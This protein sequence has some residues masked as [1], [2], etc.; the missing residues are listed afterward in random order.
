MRAFASLY[1]ALDE[2][3]RTTVKVEAMA[4]YFR[5]ADPADAA[6]AVFFL[7]GRR[8]R[9]LLSSGLLRTWSGEEADLPAWLVEECYHAV[10]D[11][12][13]TAALLLREPE[14]ISASKPLHLWVEEVILPLGDQDEDRQRE[15]VAAVWT[16]LPSFE[17]F[18]FN[19]LLTGNFRV[20]VSQKLLV[21]GLEAASAV[22]RQT[23]A[24][25]LMGTW[26]PTPRFFERLVD[27]HTEDADRSR[28]YPFCLAHPV[29][30]DPSS[31]G[32]VKEW[33]AEWKWDGIRA[34]LIRRDGETY[35][36]TR[37]EELVT[38]RY[39]EVGAA[40]TRIPD[41]TVL[42]GELLAWRDDAVLPFGQLQRRIG[43]KTVGKKLL[44]DVPVIFCAF[45]V[46]EWE[47][48]DA[49]ARPLVERRSL[50]EEVADGMDVI[51]LSERVDA[52]SW[53]DL[54]VLR[55]Q[56]RERLV[57]GLM[58][59]RLS[60]PYQVG[61]VRGDW[62]KWKVAPFT[63]DA[64]LIYAQRGSG[65]RASL[66]TDYTFALKDDGGLTPIAKAYSGLTN[67]EIREVDRWVRRNTV[68]RF[69][70]VRSVVPEL[71]F[72]LAFE[73]I[74]RSGRHKS[75]VAVRFPRIARWRRDKTAADIDRL[76]D[77]V[78]L[79]A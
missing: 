1:R 63:I 51:R 17:R 75:G 15:I 34:Q 65:K 32:P 22:D 29:E 78:K 35:I 70:P 25:R 33:L 23:L 46:M 58:L 79:L 45:D 73:G 56:S 54:A 69:G 19:K 68:E 9:R 60:S 31:L 55:G 10:G 6:W 47:G 67:E 36:W 20:G 18:V 7:S 61:R 5:E 38:D 76:E 50:L 74:R 4:A 39:P 44:A 26:A 8:F 27:P 28:P 11:T 52:H 30:V 21:R 49:R 62:W 14:T 48:E 40:S 37:G 13:E 16:G 71:V 59:K 3:T 43:R 2:S 64:V 24:H 42:D 72:E 12:A 53:E 66:Y 77:I 41:G 57:E